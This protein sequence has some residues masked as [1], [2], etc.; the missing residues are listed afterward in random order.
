MAKKTGG[1]STK[2][3]LGNSEAVLI[4][5][6]GL[7]LIG[8]LYLVIF[9]NLSGNLGFTTEAAPEI[10]NETGP[11]VSANQT[12]YTLVG[13][14]DVGAASFVITALWNSTN[15]TG[16][17]NYNVTLI[18]AANYSVTSD[19]VLRNATEEFY[20]NVSASYTHVKDSTGK[21]N[22]DNTIANLTGG[23]VTFFGFSNTL[24][25]LTAITLLIS[26]ILVVLR[27]VRGNKET[28]GFAN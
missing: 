5:L 14:S 10:F 7:G 15:A 18:E 27:L 25:T 2:Q 12:G 3:L 17:G 23:V 22:T 13:A 16:F 4:G 8:I 24:F 26:I 11:L 19:G 28:S 9:G 20:N 1:M 21:I 6:L